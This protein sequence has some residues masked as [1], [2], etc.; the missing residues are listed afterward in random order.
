MHSP[1]FIE[2]FPMFLFMPILSTLKAF[3]EI[4]HT[5]CQ[6]RIYPMYDELYRTLDTFMSSP[7]FIPDVRFKVWTLDFRMQDAV[8]CDRIAKNASW[9]K[10]RMANI[11]ISI[12]TMCCVSA[13]REQIDKEFTQLL[14]SCSYDRRHFP[15]GK[16]VFVW[17]FYFRV[18]IVLIPKG[19]CF[20]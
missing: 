14:V 3:L 1:V 9:E 7:K 13:G 15:S 4:W 6:S 20:F 18:G 8:I 17:K 2:N 19:S 16:K 11:S 5:G 10:I 12:A